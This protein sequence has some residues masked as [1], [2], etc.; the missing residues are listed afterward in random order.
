MVEVVLRESK[1][2]V[3]M[4]R[5]I[6]IAETTHGFICANAGVD[7]SNVAGNFVTLLPVDPDASARRI[8]EALEQR[9]GVR[10]GVIISDTFGRPWREGLVNVALGVAGLTPIIDLRGRQDWYGKPLHVTAIALADEL[11]S[12]AELVMGKDSGVPVSIIRGINYQPADAGGRQLIRAP[13]LDL[14]R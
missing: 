14:F 4:E 9:H 1:R 6:L 8:K 13:E 10:L 11:A 12:A 3:R 2:S 5:G 7:A